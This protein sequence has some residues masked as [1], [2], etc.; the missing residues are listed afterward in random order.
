MLEWI[1]AWAYLWPA[2]I[3][4]VVVVIVLLMVLNVALGM[5]VLGLYLLLPQDQIDR[6]MRWVV[7]V[8]RE[9]FE[10]YFR[11]VEKHLRSTFPVHGTNPND[12]PKTSLLLWHPHSLLS[13]TSVLHNCFKIVDFDSKI[14]SH[15]IYHVLP[16]IKDISRFNNSIPANFDVMR[17]NLEEGNRVS[18]MVGGVREMMETEENV[19]NLTLKSRKGVFRLALISGAP[20]VPILTYNESKLFPVVKIPMLDS[21]NKFLYSYFHIAVPITS[22][23]ALQNWVNLYSHPLDIVP[24]YVGS[25]ISVEKI[26]SPTE[27]D[28][29]DLQKKY[30]KA[31]EDLFESTKPEGYKLV[32][33]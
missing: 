23:T 14:V 9:K 24:T 28:I 33:Q 8:I 11:Q 13:V 2:C 20:L 1:L 25:P 17:S 4:A 29:N 19:L 32:I 30:I 10:H 6:L 27:K 22:I 15:S 12:L 16:I 18:V 5:T 3:A 21:I 7:D 31:V 26:E